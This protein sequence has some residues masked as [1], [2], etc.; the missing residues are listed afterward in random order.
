MFEDVP[1]GEYRVYAQEPASATS[2]GFDLDD[3]GNLDVVQVRANQVSQNIDIMLVADAQAAVI[4]DAPAT[5]HRW[6][7]DLDEAPGDQGVHELTLSPGA[8]YCN[9]WL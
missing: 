9:G 4:A 2:G 6:T 5:T 7:A 3:D 8:T 1:A